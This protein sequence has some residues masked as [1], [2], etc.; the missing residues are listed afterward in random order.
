MSRFVLVH[1]AFCGAWCW[2]PLVGE[3][4]ALGHSVDAIDL[5]GHG[6]DTTPL[7]EVTLDLYAERV[8]ET[9]A[10][11]EPAVLVGHSMGG[12]VITQTAA[13]A[14]EH[15]DRLVYCCAFLPRD[16]ESLK[17]LADKPEG[18]ADLVQANLVLAPPVATLSPEAAREA[19]YELCTPEQ[20]QWGL[21]H[22]Q[23]QPIAPFMTPVDLD[24]GVDEIDRYYVLCTE[25]KAIP[26][27][28]QRRMSTESP[29]VEVAELEADHSPFLSKTSE[30]AAILDRFANA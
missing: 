10:A 5:P 6:E 25:D 24:G 22:R 4:E 23:P 13:R 28:L 19:F 11:G 17:S 26:P 8:A 14:R 7:D 2:E 9:L 21:D 3:L 27:P 1:G 15:V 18:A 29:C 30:L 20:A 12:V 16:G